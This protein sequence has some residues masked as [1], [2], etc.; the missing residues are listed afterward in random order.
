MSLVA[1][2]RTTLTATYFH[3]VAIAVLAVGGF[4][5]VVNAA[6]VASTISPAIIGSSVICLLSRSSYICWQDAF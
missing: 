5:P 1:N 6:N 3:G 2:E 4:A